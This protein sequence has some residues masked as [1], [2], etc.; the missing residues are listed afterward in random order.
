MALGRTDERAS[1]SNWNAVPGC[2]TPRTRSARSV[3]PCTCKEVSV[4]VRR[5]VYEEMSVWEVRR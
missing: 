5:C 4:C 1:V 3:R 2:P